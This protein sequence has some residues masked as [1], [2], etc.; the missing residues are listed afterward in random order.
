MVHPRTRHHPSFTTGFNITIGIAGKDPPVPCMQEDAKVAYVRIPR[1][2]NENLNWCIKH[3]W[4]LEIHGRALIV[5]TKARNF[6]NRAEYGYYRLV[7]VVNDFT[8]LKLT[9]DYL[10]PRIIV[11]DWICKVRI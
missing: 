2:R 1:I 3:C 4:G 7:A 9:A 11:I 8:T 10:N 6:F 5:R